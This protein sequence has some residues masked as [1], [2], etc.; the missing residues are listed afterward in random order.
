MKVSQSCLTLSHI[1]YSPWNS[2]GQNTGVGTPFPLQLIFPT[3]GSNSG[4]LALQADSLPAE[5]QGKP[6]NTGVGSLSLLQWILPTQE[7]NQCLLHCRQILYQLSYQGNKIKRQP[8]DWEKV[9]ANDVTHKGLVSK[10]YKQLMTFNS[11]KTNIP[12]KKWAEDLNRQ[13]S[14]EDV[15]M[16]NRHMK[17]CSKSLLIWEM[18]IKATM[19][20]HLTPVRVATVKKST[21]HKCWR[22]CGEKGTL[23]HCWWECKLVQSLWWTVCRFLKN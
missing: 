14:T 10:I 4:S 18:Q 8:T 9:L 16:A 23:L 17:R 1:L 22:G 19:R 15:Q 11:I 5:P 3:Q 21:N 6:K 20:Y 12:L 7:P 13:F 2:P